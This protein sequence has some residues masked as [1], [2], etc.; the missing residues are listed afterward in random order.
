MNK[1]GKLLPMPLPKVL[2]KILLKLA[3][4][5]GILNLPVC[6]CLKAEL[7]R[8]RLGGG[9][10]AVDLGD[11]WPESAAVAA[12]A[13]CRVGRDEISLPGTVSAIQGTIGSAA[14]SV[15]PP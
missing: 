7:G 2:N 14:E 6:V 13:G 10:P 12:G 11:L 15:F 1:N 9:F 5:G 3:V 4:G 8:W